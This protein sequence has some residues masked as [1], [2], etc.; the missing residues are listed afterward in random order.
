MVGREPPA[1]IAAIA[2]TPGFSLFADAPDLAPLYSDAD[3][4]IAPLLAGSGTRIKILEAFSYRRAVV[5]TTLGAEGLEVEAG[6]DLLI[7]D[8]PKA[9]AAHCAALMRHVRYRRQIADAG[10]SVFERKYTS[11]VLATILGRQF[12][13]A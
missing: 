1:Q 10:Y 2:K 8:E 9:F 5:S 13:L 7:A 6:K 4:V 12:G 3:V 11:D